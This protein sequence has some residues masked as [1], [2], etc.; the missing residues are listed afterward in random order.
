MSG[1]CSSPDSG[2]P[3]CA[4]QND[5]S[6]GLNS[7][8]TALQWLHGGPISN[9][10]TNMV[11]M[12]V[13][14]GVVAPVEP[15]VSPLS[16][17]GA[18]R[19]V[20]RNTSSQF[21]PLAKLPT[22][23]DEEQA[24]RGD[25]RSK[26]PYSYAQLI[27]F[28]INGSQHQ[29]LT[30]SEIY[31]WISEKFPFYKE[32][33]SHAWKNS[34]R[35]N[36]SL[37]KCFVKQPR[38][39]DD[40]GK[41]SYWTVQPDELFDGR[42]GYSRSRHASRRI[43]RQ[44]SRSP[45]PYPPSHAGNSGWVETPNMDIPGMS[46]Q[47]LSSGLGLAPSPISRSPVASP[48]LA[49]GEASPLRAPRQDG[50]AFNDPAD[51]TSIQ[52][53][54]FFPPQSPVFENT[55]P[56][57]LQREQQFAAPSHHLSIPTPMQLSRDRSG[58]DPGGLHTNSMSGNAQADKRHTIGNPEAFRQVLGAHRQ[59]YAMHG[60]FG[61]GDTRGAAAAIPSLNLDEPY[62]TAPWNGSQ[63]MRT[64][65]FSMDSLGTS[66]RSIQRSSSACSWN[67]DMDNLRL[68][69]PLTTSG[70]SRTSLNQQQQ[71]MVI[72][73]GVPASASNN[74]Q[75]EEVGTLSIPTIPGLTSAS[76]NSILNR[77]VEEAYKK[78]DLEGRSIKSAD[79]LAQEM[80]SDEGDSQLFGT[81]Q[82]GSAM[83]VDACS[84]AYQQLAHANGLPDFMT[85]PAYPPQHLSPTGLPLQNRNG[86]TV[87]QQHARSH[88][89][90]PHTGPIEVF[91]RPPSPAIGDQG[92]ATGLVV[93]QRI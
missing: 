20:R 40:P 14:P 31:A 43:E 1:S 81:W 63:E 30:L 54:A 71:A 73:S 84:T 55:N 75:S 23:D 9:L 72:G 16:G 28:S 41:G 3:D 68:N 45:S 79:Q 59:S 33:Q 85:T 19:S 35:H 90:S 89:T 37:F 10:P 34:I 67:A 46:G 87:A 86:L 22:T 25:G 13:Q 82:S 61:N 4:G 92:P 36:L 44:I 15:C 42:S 74:G 65:G 83:L 91:V 6:G 58:S 11:M 53:R 39:A 69:T 49:S 52:G 77:A 8:L 60:M 62:P 88:S 78:G 76:V 17:G 32:G 51:F 48:Y 80:M 29:R 66:P 26:P 56:T 38:P 93:A 70:G 2:D 24:S 27:A 64:E 57:E 21:D 18:N 50:V 47:S 5:G 12:E 7:S